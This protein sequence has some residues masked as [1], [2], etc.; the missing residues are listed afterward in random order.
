MG[1]IEEDR[2]RV[3]KELANS[4]TEDQH[5]YFDALKEHLE[6]QMRE[7]VHT[8]PLE[9][10]REVY[11]LMDEKISTIT[12]PSIKCKKGCSF[13]CHLNVDITRLEAKLIAHYC[14]EQNI[15]IDKNY[16]VKQAEYSIDDIISSPHSACVFLKNNECSIYP[17]RPCGC[18]KLFVTTDPV[19][20]DTHKDDRTPVGILFFLLLEMITEA[21]QDVD[22]HYGSLPILMLPYAK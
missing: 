1:F 4:L 18:R 7:H 3:A 16:L 6:R 2:E 15:P 8:A 13:C 10:M 5:K 11:R 20:C 21:V 19:F 22:G 12:E 14:N 17:V 9:V